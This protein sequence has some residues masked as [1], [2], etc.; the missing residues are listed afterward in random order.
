[1]NL[2]NSLRLKLVALVSVTLVISMT[3]M[4]GFAIYEIRSLLMQQVTNETESLARSTGNEVGLWIDARKAEIGVIGNSPVL[5]SGDKAAILTYLKE[6]QKR[7]PL[8]EAFIVADPQ[9]NFYSSA[10]G[11]GNI[12]DRKYFQD[13]IK[14]QTAVSDL[15]TARATGNTVICVAAP[16]Y[17]DGKII[18][19]VGGNVQVGEIMKIVNQV[20][21]GDKG[22]AMLIQGDGLL[23]THPRQEFIR[24]YNLLEQKDNS[25]ELTSAVKN[26]LA[27]QKGYIQYTFENQE[28]AMGYAPVPGMTW[29]VGVVGLVSELFS[30]MKTLIGFSILL[31]IVILLLS[32]GLVA[33]YSNKLMWRLAQIKTGAEQLANGDLTGSME[34]VNAK[35]EIGIL[36]HAFIQMRDNLKSLIINVSK[37]AEQVAAAS[38]ELTAG[39]EQSAQAAKQIATSISGVASG[40]NEQLSA[41]G[42]TLVV[43]EKM[44]ANIQQVAASTNQV[45]EQST[46]AADKAA[47]GSKA[48]EKAVSQMSFIENTVNT[49]AKVVAKLGERS[50]EIGQIVDTISGIAGQTNLLALNAAIEAARAGEQGRGFAVVAEEVRKLAEQSQDA[51]KKIAELIGEIQGET[52]QAVRAMNDGTREV[53]TGAEVVNDA[54]AAFQEIVE[55]VSQVSTQMREIS[56]AIQ[57]TA[58]GSQQIVG[59]VK[60]IDSLSK[61][62]A[63][64]A[65]TVSAA[66]QEQL[67]SMEEIA[68][69]SQEL[70]KLAQNLQS[71]VG[72]FRV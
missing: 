60:Q 67:A 65:Q 69:S 71:A 43:V 44:S 35:D 72:K 39:S 37:M 34:V 64:E 62:S 12:T 33:Y 6:E 16:I 22:Y 58:S 40:A 66:T 4:A 17:L 68:S 45:S 48:I 42:E 2:Q 29:G 53:K 24:E 1:M 7:Q 19:I 38:E 59:P 49:S 61:T 21:V 20:K 51:A 9:G 55:L 18:G 32:V 14:G 28:K 36:G 46:R 3:L 63:G 50:K 56:A 31:A 52:D 30:R 23:A 27:G 54:G 5:R 57:E 8:F 70:A 10:T 15:I 11:S 25:P 26:M 47:E 13:A 41:A